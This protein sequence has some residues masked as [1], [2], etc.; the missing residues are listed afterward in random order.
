MYLTQPW[1]DTP[2]FSNTLLPNDLIPWISKHII[3]PWF[4]PLVTQISHPLLIWY[5]GFSINP[6]TPE[7]QVHNFFTFNR[8]LEQNGCIDSCF[9]SKSKHNYMH[10]RNYWRFLTGKIAK[11]DCKNVNLL[12]LKFSIPIRFK[13]ALQYSVKTQ[14]YKMIVCLCH[15]TM[16]FKININ[17][18]NTS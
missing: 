14:I 8:V 3:N 9:N 11:S 6:L 16:K 2:G 15:F 10:S 17:E 4:L 1:S 12:T 13:I 5:P 18:K 7:G